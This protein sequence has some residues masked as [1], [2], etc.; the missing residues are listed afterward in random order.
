V[1]GCYVGVLP[2]ESKN[3]IALY[4]RYRAFK[5][6]YYSGANEWFPD[7]SLFKTAH[8]SSSEKISSYE[9]FRA[10]ELRGRWFVRP[11]W[12]LDVNIPYVQS[13]ESEGV[14]K[15]TTKGLGDLSFSVMRHI[16][17]ESCD[18][19]FKNRLIVGG[20]IKLPTGRNDFML[21]NGQRAAFYNQPGTGSI[22]YNLSVNYAIAYK[23]LGY[24]ISTNFRYNTT[25]T[26]NERLS[27]IAN[28]SSMLFYKWNVNDAWMV[29]PSLINTFEKTKG[30]RIGSELQKGT[31]MQ[32]MMMGAGLQI[33]HKRIA[34]DSQLF[35]PL[36]EPK[37]INSQQSTIRI[38]I[39]LSYNI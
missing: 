1:C 13:V 20:G 9:V 36:D 16:V 4:T 5:N 23:K 31:A 29:V 39:G 18:R 32:L 25:N 28:V 7:G 14:N 34:L 12:E 27:S 21:S 37:S 30:V 15:S 11:K 2:Y 35:L 3:S 8:S 17:S 26:F 33:I 6:E 38:V 24:S 19:Q 22:D 10:Y